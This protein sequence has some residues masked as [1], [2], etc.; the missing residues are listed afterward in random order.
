[1]TSST[2]FTA[3]TKKEQ[4]GTRLCFRSHLTTGPLFLLKLWRVL[5]S[6]GSTT[7]H[8][9]QIWMESKVFLDYF[10]T[11]LTVGKIGRRTNFAPFGLPFCPVWALPLHP[12]GSLLLL[13][14]LFW[15]FFLPFWVPTAG[16]RKEAS[17][18]AKEKEQESEKRKKKKEGR[19]KKKEE[20]KRKRKRVKK[21]GNK[22]KRTKK[23]ERRQNGNHPTSLT[24]AHVHHKATPQDKLRHLC[25]IQKPSAT[26][27]VW[28]SQDENC[29]THPSDTVNS[30][31]QEV[32][33]LGKV[34]TLL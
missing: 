16:A 20:R 32:T 28:F 22:K 34:L 1:M 31:G 4:P 30:F 7:R 21:G 24:D 9:K 27:V 15:M 19:R 14:F 12:L 6:P 26:D 25:R 11:P 18:Q 13:F 10:P 33:S 29:A 8:T 2:V 23:R 5:V 17:K 3:R